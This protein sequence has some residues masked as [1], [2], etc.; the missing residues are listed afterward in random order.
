M[1]YTFS[2]NIKYGY[3]EVEN[4][5][6]EGELNDYYSEKYFQSLMLLW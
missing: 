1:E 4:K 6:S 5:P 2:K 3:F